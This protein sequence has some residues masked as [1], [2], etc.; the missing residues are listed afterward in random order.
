LQEVCDDLLDND[1]DGFIDCDDPD[2][3][4]GTIIKDPAQIKLRPSRIDRLSFSG[5]VIPASPAQIDPLNEPV[6]FLLTNANGAIYRA[7]L[8]PGDLKGSAIKFGF[9]DPSARFGSGIRDGLYKVKGF[10]R[11]GVYHFNVFAYA[12][13]S[14]ATLPT[15]TLQIVVGDDAFFTKAN[16]TRTSRGWRYEFPRIPRAVP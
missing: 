6:G 3:L 9:R 15:M 10:L 5:G 12:D 7:Q 14:A 8:Q 4:C 11:N 1:G 13:L 2:C 16:W